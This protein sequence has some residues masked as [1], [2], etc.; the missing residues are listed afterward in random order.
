MCVDQSPR[1]LSP[2]TEL[3]PNP[4]QHR[5]FAE[6][7]LVMD[8]LSRRREVVDPN[9]IQAIVAARAQDATARGRD[10]AITR[11]Q[12]AVAFLCGQRATVTAREHRSL[13]LR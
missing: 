1:Q 2:G 6:A 5:N 7:S 3:N 9:V 10:V 13:V 11:A 8:E 4:P 12:D